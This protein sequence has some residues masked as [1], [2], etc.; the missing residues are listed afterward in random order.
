MTRATRR[1][2]SPSREVPKAQ[3]VWKSLPQYAREAVDRD[4]AIRA[5]YATGAFTL[6]QIG[7]YFGLHYAT[8]SRIAR[9]V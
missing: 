4:E 5:A 7:A 8:V 9:R 6:T 2:E 1:A 3:R